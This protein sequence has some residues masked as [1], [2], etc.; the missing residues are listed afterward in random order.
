MYLQKNQE[1]VFANSNGEM[2]A[3]PFSQL[4]CCFQGSTRTAKS[5]IFCLYV[6]VLFPQQGKPA[7]DL[8]QE[9]WICGVIKHDL[10][11]SEVDSSLREQFTRSNYGEN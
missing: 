1:T 8:Q 7:D 4:E 5:R 10:F 11:F 3:T 2:S 9:M 6:V